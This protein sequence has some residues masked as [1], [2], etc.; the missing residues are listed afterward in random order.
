MLASRYKPSAC[1][2]SLEPFLSASPAV[3]MHALPA[4]A[5]FMLGAIH[6]IAPKGALV[7]LS[8]GVLRA[9]WREVPSHRRVM[10]PVFLGALLV[11]GLFTLMPGRIMQDVVFGTCSAHGSCGSTCRERAK[12][13]RRWLLAHV[14]RANC[15]A[16]LTS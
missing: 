12:T 9:C 14:V 13:S 11:A 3:R 10:Q 16:A 4:I 8:L 15:D 1:L 2:I 7:A 5:A 6:L